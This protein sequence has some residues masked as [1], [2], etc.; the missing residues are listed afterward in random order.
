MVEEPSD[1]NILSRLT[2]DSSYKN[3]PLRVIETFYL[4][5]KKELTFEEIIEEVQVS[6]SAIS[7]ALKILIES[8][9][10]NYRI[11]D[12]NKRK[13]YFFLDVEGVIRNIQ[14]KTQ[15]YEN[16]NIQ[17]KKILK[18]RKT[19]NIELNNFIKALI[20]YNKDLISFIKI[21]TQRYFNQ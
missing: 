1:I 14:S 16:Q 6:K 18:L 13:R 15:F 19:Q 11:K 2:F 20:N 17:L 12:G 5:H 21:K 10:I 4:S 8:G 9:E 7:K 3:I